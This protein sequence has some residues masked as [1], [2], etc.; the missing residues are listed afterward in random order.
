MKFKFEVSKKEFFDIV[1][2]LYTKIDNNQI[3]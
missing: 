3:Y 1:A 2:G